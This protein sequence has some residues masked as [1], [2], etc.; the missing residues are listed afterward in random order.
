MSDRKIPISDL[1]LSSLLACTL[2]LSVRLCSADASPSWT[3]GS[4]LNQSL[5]SSHAVSSVSAT[6]ANDTLLEEDALPY[7]IEEQEEAGAVDEPRIVFL[8]RSTLLKV[9]DRRLRFVGSV[10]SPYPLRC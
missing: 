7:E 1:F 6:I 8:F 3:D 2:F 10:L 9:P 4:C 5:T